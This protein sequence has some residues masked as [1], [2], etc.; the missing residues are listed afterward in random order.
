M[1]CKANQY[2]IRLPEF[3]W[4][5]IQCGVAHCVIEHEKSHYSYWCQEIPNGCKGQPDYSVPHMSQAKQSEDHQRANQATVKCLREA[6]KRDP[7]K[8]CKLLFNHKGC[9][10]ECD[11]TYGQGT[12]RAEACKSSRKCS[13]WKDW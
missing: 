9:D 2:I 13:P 12:D 4:D 5:E 10:A 1:T 6:Q 3:T 7:S 11:A 8:P